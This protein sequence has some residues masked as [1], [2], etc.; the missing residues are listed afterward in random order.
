MDR[1]VYCRIVI[2]PFDLICIVDYIVLLI[3]TIYH[4]FCTA[5]LRA[6]YYRFIVVVTSQENT[7]K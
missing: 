7:N 5:K 2:L 3:I 1:W 6:R 4:V